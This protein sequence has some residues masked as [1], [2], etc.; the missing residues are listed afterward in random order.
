MFR[1]IRRYQRRILQ[2]N[3]QFTNKQFKDSSLS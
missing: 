3:R 1:K 2:P